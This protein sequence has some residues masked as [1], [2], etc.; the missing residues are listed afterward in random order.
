MAKKENFIKIRVMR[1]GGNSM[2]RIDG[3]YYRAPVSFFVKESDLD[4]ILKT[5]N[6]QRVS[7]EDILVGE[8]EIKLG[9]KIKKSEEDVEVKSI[10]SEAIK[11]EVNFN[12]TVEDSDVDFSRSEKKS[13]KRKKS[14]NTK[15]EV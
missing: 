3:R 5:L 2:L 12:T 10:K 11:V 14:E 1:C 4:K 7:S 15:S 8:K 9:R 13:S 6:V